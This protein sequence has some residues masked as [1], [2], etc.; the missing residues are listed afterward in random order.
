MKGINK[1][2]REYEKKKSDMLCMQDF[3]RAV[4]S[5]HGFSEHGF[6][7]HGFVEELSLVIV[8]GFNI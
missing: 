2:E 7:E 3:E 5:Q 6:F 4:F 8:Q 1:G